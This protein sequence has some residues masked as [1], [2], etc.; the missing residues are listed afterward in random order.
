MRKKI[1][2][3]LEDKARELHDMTDFEFSTVRGGVLYEEA[4][5]ALRVIGELGMGRNKEVLQNIKNST[6]CELI[7]DAIEVNDL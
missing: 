6:T 3:I 4:N 5:E 1:A 7:H 2:K